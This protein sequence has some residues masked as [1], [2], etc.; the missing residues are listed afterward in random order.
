VARPA[1]YQWQPLGLDTDPVPGDPQAL[2]QEAHHLSSVANTIARQV[3]ALRKIAADTTET[4]QHADKIRS[5]ALTLAT[6]L[7]AVADRYQKVS[8]ALAGWVPELE[9]AQA[10]S[11]RALDEAEAPYAMLHRV[12][13]LPS[14][15]NLTTAQKEEIAAYQASM[16]RAKEQL[17]EA[18]AQLTRAT[19]LRDT[20]G[21]YYAAKINQ[22]SND[23]LTDHESFWDHYAWLVKD[24]CTGLEV[25]ATA[26][27]IVAFI[28][29]QFVPGVDLIVD[30]IVVGAFFATLGATVGR[31]IM[32]DTGN[33]SWWDFGLDAFACLTFG[34]GRFLGLAAR[35]L[36]GTAEVASKSAMVSELA[37]G[38][39]AKAVELARFADL[40][41]DDVGELAAKFAPKLAQTAVKTATANYELTGLW[42][43]FAN[44]GSLSK[45][46][47]EFAKALAVSGRF[48]DTM[49]T[50]SK[51]TKL[52][53]ATSGAAAGL[54]SVTGVGSLAF[55]G[56][57]L[58]GPRGPTLIDWHIPGVSNWY[59]STFEIPTGG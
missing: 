28:L 47:E 12:T 59:E 43:V 17:D 25:L 42:K 15:T 4:G 50:I 16:R 27:A 37:A 6:S 40:T 35:T 9:Q 18:Q 11:I 1:G 31:F 38:S 46:S 51:L 7:Q 29:A 41:G 53:L 49:G 5:A 52:A 14:G 55:G 24:I 32:A 56:V 13:V 58:D 23:S 33:G 3:G 39:G 54:T 21:D 48:A 44:L 34:A 57:E 26:A 20:Q 2:S 8:A 19:A 22:A 30:W 10:L 36:R 45:E